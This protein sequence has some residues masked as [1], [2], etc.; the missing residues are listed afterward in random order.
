MRTQQAIDYF[1]SAKALADRLKISQSSVS[2]WGEFPPPAR[3]LQI[4][5][6]TRKALRAEPGSLDRVLGLA[7]E[8]ANA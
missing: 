7:K 1:H 3:Q 8:P 2:Q 5:K 6:V 4:E